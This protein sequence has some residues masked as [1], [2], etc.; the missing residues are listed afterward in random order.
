MVK[1]PT[2]YSTLKSVLVEK[3]ALPT[4]KELVMSVTKSIQLA[5][6]SGTPMIEHASF[7]FVRNQG[8]KVCYNCDDNSGN[9][10]QNTCTKPKGD[11]DVCGNLFSSVCHLLST[12]N[13]PR[14]CPKP[15]SIAPG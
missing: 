12:K 15:H 11:C 5:K 10:F 1:L 7:A 4:C 3:D 6:V 2:E 13:S 14:A 8:S 9:H